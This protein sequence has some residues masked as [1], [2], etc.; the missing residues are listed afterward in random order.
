MTTAPTL[1]LVG[2]QFSRT[3]CPTCK[4]KGRVPCPETV[5]VR[6]WGPTGPYIQPSTGHPIPCPECNGLRLGT[7]RVHP[8]A[9]YREALIGVT[10]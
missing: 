3:I 2:G 6:S 10:L 8:A 1:Q 5:S 9:E 4:G 7:V